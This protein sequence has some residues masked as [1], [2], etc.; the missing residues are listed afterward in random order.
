MGCSCS[1]INSQKK[2]TIKKDYKIILEWKTDKI[3]EHYHWW[4]MKENI[5]DSYANNLYSKDGGLFKYDLLFNTKS[6]IYQKNN[7]YF[8]PNSLNSNSNWSGFCDKAAILSCL[9]KYPKY[10]VVVEYN[11]QQIEFKKHDIEALMIVS[12]DNAINKNIS[13]FFGE[14]N[15]NNKYNEPYPSDLIE[16]FKIIASSNE[17][18]IID[19]DNTK[20]V[21]NF[22]Y[23]SIKIHEYDYCK[24]EHTK[25][26]KGITKY[27][28]FIIKSTAYPNYNIDIW[29]Y[30]NTIVFNEDYNITKQNQKWISKNHPD[31]IWKT[32]P[33]TTYWEGKSKINPEID[34]SI[35]YLIYRHSLQNNN[36]I[37]NINNYNK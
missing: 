4:P 19:I 16:I 27:Y 17:P 2:N 34:S 9:Y 23:D 6:N 8:E 1:L 10:N 3:I 20:A 30:I 31:F 22:S 12:A 13:L 28:N 29:G 18:F 7:F 15:Y 35:T 26:E 33:K 36:Q 14:R 25:P 11:N 24:L 5:N 32:N 37:L 21:W